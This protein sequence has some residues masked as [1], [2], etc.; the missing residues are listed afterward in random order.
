MRE[1]LG[2]KGK[3]ARGSERGERRE[4]ELPR[5]FTGLQVPDD[6]AAALQRLQLGL[7]G[8]RWIERADLHLTLRFLGDVPGPV[9]DDFAARL[10]E[11]SEAPFRLEIK[12]LG[13]FGGEKPRMVYAAISPCE[14]LTNL[15]R[16]HERAAVLA[17]LS[18]EGRKFTPHVT[19]ARVRHPAPLDVAQYMAAFGGF[20]PLEFEVDEFCLY[21][22]KQS[23]GGG[24]YV[25]EETFPLLMGAG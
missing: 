7:P 11:M 2:R 15:Q 19:L 20:A 13:V 17:G 25:I 24:P 18:P 23:R 16:A 8:A 6:C 1:V 3:H 21:S 22:A 10:D 4:R 5:L 14:A 9:A 12:G